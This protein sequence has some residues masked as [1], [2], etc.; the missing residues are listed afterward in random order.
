MASAPMTQS[1]YVSSVAS[2]YYTR[3]FVNASTYVRGGGSNPVLTPDPDALRSVYQ[4]SLDYYQ[5]YIQSY[6]GTPIGGPSDCGH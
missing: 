6:N 1:A 4:Q 2:S 5:S 3:I